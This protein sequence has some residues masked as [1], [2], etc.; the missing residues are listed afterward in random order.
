MDAIYFDQL[1]VGDSCQSP[2][3]TVTETDIVNFAGLSGDFVQLHTDAEYCKGTYFG[4]RMAHGLLGMSI[5]SGLGTRTDLIAGISQTVI[6]L[7]GMDW[8]FK[9]PIFI[10]DTIHV[11]LEVSEKRETSKPDRGVIVLLRTVFNQHGEIVQQGTTPL[12]L[13]R[14]PAEA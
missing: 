1:N 3:R 2:G 7:L 11:V 9:A 14:K 6:A 12:M 10:D 5:A 8:K 4:Q 13:K